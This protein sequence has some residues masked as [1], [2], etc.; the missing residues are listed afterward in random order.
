MISWIMGNI[1]TI[2]ITFFLILMVAGIIISM[3]KD[4]K[5]GISSCGGNCAH[6]K[7]TCGD[8]HCSRRDIPKSDNA[9]SV[10]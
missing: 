9:D 5:R 4:K 3:V 1:G 7:I 8:I 6:C 10:A 2:I